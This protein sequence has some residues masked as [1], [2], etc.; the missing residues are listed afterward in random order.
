MQE[1][2]AAQANGQHGERSVARVFWAGQPSRL[3]ASVVRFQLRAMLGSRSSVS[4][5]ARM[6]ASVM[7]ISVIAAA[8]MLRAAADYS[9]RGL[10]QGFRPRS[11][12]AFWWQTLSRSRRDQAA[13]RRPGSRRDGR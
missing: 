6:V 3:A 1:R 2:P 8:P 7:V 13:D 11:I 9:H 12:G 5:E 10:V 4:K